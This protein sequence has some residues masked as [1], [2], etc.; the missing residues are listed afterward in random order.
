VQAR[1]ALRKELTR[2]LRTRRARWPQ[3]LTVMNGHRKIHGMM[4]ISERPPE[5]ADRAAPGSLGWRHHVRRS[6][7]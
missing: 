3:G 6:Q 7:D 2:C 5:A 4:N 1:A